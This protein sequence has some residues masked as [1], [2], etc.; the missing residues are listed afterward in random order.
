MR[1]G[2]CCSCLNHQV[3]GLKGSISIVVLLKM[4][5]SA[6]MTPIVVY[7][8][9]TKDPNT[10]NLTIVNATYVTIVEFGVKAW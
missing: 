3:N 6:L 10:P 9:E 1:F 4:D 2:N 7:W 5:S 8:I